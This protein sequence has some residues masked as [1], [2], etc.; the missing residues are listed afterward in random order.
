MAYVKI[1]IAEESLLPQCTPSKSVGHKTT[2]VFSPVQDV[3]ENITGSK[4]V[5]GQKRLEKAN[6]SWATYPHG[7][8]ATSIEMKPEWILTEHQLNNIPPRVIYNQVHISRLGQQVQGLDPILG[9][10]GCL[11]QTSQTRLAC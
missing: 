1:V 6:S 2:L 5:H 3:Q 7:K 10:L 11:P 9:S 4:I 8:L